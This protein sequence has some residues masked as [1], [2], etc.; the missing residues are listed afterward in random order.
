MQTAIAFLVCVLLVPSI[1]ATLLLDR[2]SRIRARRITH[3]DDYGTRRT[4]R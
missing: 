2:A 4:I 3:I 1:V